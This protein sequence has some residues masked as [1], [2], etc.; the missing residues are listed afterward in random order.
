L[1]GAGGANQPIE[2]DQESCKRF[3]GTGGC[4][5]QH[6]AAGSNFGP[7]ENLRLGG[8]GEASGKPL[9]DERVKIREY[10]RKATVV[11]L[12]LGIHVSLF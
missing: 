2:A 6:V 1:T 10:R 5:N 11:D 12:R 3:A 8:P 7:S 9:C 4:R